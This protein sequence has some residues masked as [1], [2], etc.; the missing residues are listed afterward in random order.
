AVLH[1]GPQARAYGAPAEHVQVPARGR[2]YQWELVLRPLQR[3]D[4]PHERLQ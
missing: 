3:H 4:G 1:Q 2:F